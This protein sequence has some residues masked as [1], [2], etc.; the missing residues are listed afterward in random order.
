VANDAINPGQTSDCVLIFVHRSLRVRD[1]RALSGSSA[2]RLHRMV[3]LALAR[4]F[5]RPRRSSD[6]DLCVCWSGSRQT[7]R[8]R[9][10]SA[11][12]SHLAGSIS[13]RHGL[14]RGS[15]KQQKI[16]VRIFDNESFCAPR[17]PFQSL[18]KRDAS[19]LKLNKQQFDFAR[20]ANGD[21]CRQQSLA[22]S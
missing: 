16:L 1:G 18:V 4:V 20:C 5:A 19:R 10:L 6:S 14:G 12:G 17:L 9:W 21:R 13:G 7:R 8:D 2:R 3:R 15:G 11:S 22:I